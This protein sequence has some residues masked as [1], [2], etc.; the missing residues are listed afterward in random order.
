MTGRISNPDFFSRPGLK[1]DSSFVVPLKLN[2][3]G[4]SAG[5]G[6]AHKVI[7][8]TNANMS[9]P[10]NL[11]REHNIVSQEEWIAARKE[12]LKMEK[13]SAR[14]ADQLSAERRK[15]PWVKVEKKRLR[16]GVRL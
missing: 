1:S 10:Y 7:M 2:K 5:A 15:L 13:E 11:K 16:L 8:S 14:L 4:W 3:N 9:E 6:S 12:L